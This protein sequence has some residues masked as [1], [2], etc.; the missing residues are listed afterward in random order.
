M[1][2]SSEPCTRSDRVGRDAPYRRTVTGISLVACWSSIVWAVLTL[3]TCTQSETAPPASSRIPGSTPLP[4]A[5]ATAMLQRFD[6]PLVKDLRREQ[7]GWYGN[8]DSLRTQS[9]LIFNDIGASFSARPGL[10]GLPP[11]PGHVAERRRLL[12]LVV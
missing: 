8:S 1:S 3:S 11:G 4:A 6:F 12:L 9:S 7:H 10:G 5:E 2:S